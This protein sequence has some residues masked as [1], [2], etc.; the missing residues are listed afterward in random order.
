MSDYLYGLFIRILQ[1]LIKVLKNN[2]Y[3][4]E[5]FLLVYPSSVGTQGAKRVTERLL[6]NVKNLTCAIHVF[7]MNQ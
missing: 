3:R 4:I 5:R 6:Y 2:I 7:S 1:N